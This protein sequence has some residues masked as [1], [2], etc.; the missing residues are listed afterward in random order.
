VY[1][2]NEVVYGS[3]LEDEARDSN[4][5]ELDDVLLHREKVH[6][7]ESSVWGG[8]LQR[9]HYVEAVPITQTEIHENHIGIDVSG[10]LDIEAAVPARNDTKVRALIEESGHTLAQQRVILDDQ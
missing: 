5:D 7:D 9:F 3:V 8:F 10:F 2:A 6:Q 4:F 1:R